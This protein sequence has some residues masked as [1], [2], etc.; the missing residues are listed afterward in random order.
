MSY[1]KLRRLAAA[2]LALVLPLSG[3]G[4]AV[5]TDAAAE[6]PEGQKLIALTFDDGPR[7]PPPPACW[8]AWRSGG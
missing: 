1:G 7:P 3:C 5:E 4:P 2:A 6:L 8:T